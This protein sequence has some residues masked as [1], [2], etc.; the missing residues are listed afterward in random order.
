MDL[1]AGLWWVN[2]FAVLIAVIAANGAWMIWYSPGF[3]GK[4]WMKLLGLTME[5]LNNHNGK[6][7]M[8]AGMWTVIIV[9]IVMALLFWWA[10]IKTWLVMWFIL[11]VWI[12]WMNRA[13]HYTYAQKPKKLFWINTWFDVLTFLI[14]WAIIW[15]M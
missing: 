3:F 15:G 13:M 6:V 5:S 1:L 12:I 4:D 2:Y 14:M 7:R 11:S 8:L 9:A 10:W